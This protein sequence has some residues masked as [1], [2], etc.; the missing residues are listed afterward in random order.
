MPN[1]VDTFF[2]NPMGELGTDAAKKEIWDNQQNYIGKWV[3]CCY[4]EL[5]SDEIP[6]HPR[7]RNF[8]KGKSKD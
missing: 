3:T 2:A 4:L 8:R 5:T 7:A 6:R 1:G